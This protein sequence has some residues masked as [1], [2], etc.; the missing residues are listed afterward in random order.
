MRPST[1]FIALSTFV[2]LSC[3]KAGGLTPE[4]VLNK[5]SIANSGLRS[6]RIQV[7]VGVSTVEGSNNPINGTVQVTGNIQE[8]GQQLDLLYS[9]EGAIQTQPK[10]TSWKSS[11]RFIVISQDESY[12][13]VKELQ[14]SLPISIFGFDGEKN[15]LNTWFRLPSSGAQSTSVT[16]DPRFLRLQ[17]EAVRVQKDYGIEKNNGKSLYHYSVSIDRD[18]LA[19]FIRN[20]SGSGSLQANTDLVKQLETYEATGELWI[21]SETFLLSKAA[22]TIKNTQQPDSV[23]TLSMTVSD[24]GV[25]VVISAPN[26]VQPFPNSS[27]S[28]SRNA[29][30]LQTF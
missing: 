5:A 6:A 14:T 28:P 12:I 4:N 7:Q 10:E 19:A 25:P 29:T 16:P 8:G 26:E 15:L 24:V 2:L 3:T 9:T 30:I 22:W 13:L 20:A 17:S 27:L 18:R 1:L 23:I 11:G 21:D